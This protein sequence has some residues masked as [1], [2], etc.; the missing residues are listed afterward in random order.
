MYYISIINNILYLHI[1]IYIVYYVIYTNMYT[2]K[3]NYFTNERAKTKRHLL[4]KLTEMS[5]LTTRRTTYN[6]LFITIGREALLQNGTV[7]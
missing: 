3:I 5:A 4:D 7:L 1:Y 2:V 6:L